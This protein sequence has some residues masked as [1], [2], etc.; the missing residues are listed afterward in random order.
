MK[1]ASVRAGSNTNH[2]QFP[3]AAVRALLPAPVGSKVLGSVRPRPPTSTF[4]DQIVRT[5]V[6][7]ELPCWHA[8]L[9]TREACNT[10][11]LKQDSAAAGCHRASPACSSREGSA[12]LEEEQND[13]LNRTGKETA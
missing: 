6:E 7:E 4:Q 1:E 3:G 8:L 2:L 5:Q 12:L 9:Y 13:T 11:M 10:L